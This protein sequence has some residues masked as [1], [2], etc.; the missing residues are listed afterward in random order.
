[1]GW[2]AERSLLMVARDLQSTGL[3]AATLS[4]DLKDISRLIPVGTAVSKI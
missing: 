1:M 4:A 3:P 2:I